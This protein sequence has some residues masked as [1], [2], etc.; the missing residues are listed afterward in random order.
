MSTNEVSGSLPE[1]Y[2]ALQREL[3]GLLTRPA[4]R[5][6]FGFWRSGFRVVGP[7]Q[8]P[9]IRRFRKITDP[10]SGVPR[11]R[12]SR[13]FGYALGSPNSWKLLYYHP[14]QH[15]GGAFFPQTI[16]MVFMSA[17]ITAAVLV[18]TREVFS[19]EWT[20]FIYIYTPHVRTLNPKP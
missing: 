17:V 1:K 4:R 16:D 8:A 20:T 18:L 13:Y 12:I 14:K 2:P 7:D 15:I 5:S 3:T 9:P 11:V 10:F 6:W 19:K